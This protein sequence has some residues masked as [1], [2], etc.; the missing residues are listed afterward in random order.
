VDVTDIPEVQIGDEVTLLSS[1][2]DSPISAVA[3]A[4][5]LDTIPYEILTSIG[6]RVE[7]VYFSE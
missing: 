4:K 1:N 5:Q 6:P 7:R 3:L 2:P